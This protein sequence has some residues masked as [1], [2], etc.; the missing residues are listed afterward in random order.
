VCTHG[1][2]SAVAIDE[3]QMLFAQFGLP[4]MIVTNNG[5]CFF[6]TEFEFFLSRTGIKH[7]TS[8]P[9]HQSSNSLAERAVQLLETPIFEIYGNILQTIA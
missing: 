9:Y 4:E 1:S 3:L 8:T 6:S 5:I 7:L 2:P